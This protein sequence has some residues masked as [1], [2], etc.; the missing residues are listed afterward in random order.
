VGE[1]DAK[2]GLEP[3][4][5]FVVHGWPLTLLE[6]FP[7]TGGRSHYRI[8]AEVR[9]IRSGEHGAVGLYFAGTTHP[10]PAAPVLSFRQVSFNDILDEVALLWLPLPEEVRKQIPRP[11]GNRV[12]F[13]TRFFA[14]SPERPLMNVTHALD[15]PDLFQPAG[16]GG[17]PGDWRTI[18]VT[19][20]PERTMPT[21]K[22][23]PPRVRILWDGQRVGERNR[24]EIIAIHD[25][26]ITT[27]RQNNPAN[28]GNG[29]LVPE[30]NLQGGIGLYLYESFAAFRNVRVE[31]LDGPDNPD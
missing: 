29:G 2:A 22:R 13:L 9:H 20:V 12:K 18:E 15:E 7:D 31:A 11:K 25:Q 16:H 8:H 5:T 24:D 1:K 14:D 28:P 23:I 10:T 6:L 3:D 4:G 26:I 21:G 27:F 19:V 30:I 17:K